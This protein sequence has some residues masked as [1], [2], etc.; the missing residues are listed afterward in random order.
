MTPLEATTVDGRNIQTLSTTWT[1]STPKLNV[2][3]LVGVFG[4]MDET[5]QTLE[6]HNSIKSCSTLTFGGQGLTKVIDTGV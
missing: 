5:N 6:T 3:D 1:P 2:R 4:R